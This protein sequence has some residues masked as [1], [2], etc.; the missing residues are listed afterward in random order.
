MSMKPKRAVLV[1]IAKEGEEFRLRLDDLTHQEGLPVT[2]KQ[3]EHFTS[4]LLP[5]RAFEELEFDEKLL[6]DFGYHIL[7]RLHAFKECGEI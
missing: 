6:A 4:K 5:E 3:M 1:S 2:W 7:A